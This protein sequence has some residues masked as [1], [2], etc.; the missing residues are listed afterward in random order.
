MKKLKS[1]VIVVVMALVLLVTGVF[2]LGGL[3]STKA[4]A[5]TQ[6][7]AGYYFCD[8]VPIMDE[9]TLRIEYKMNNIDYDIQPLISSQKLAYLVYTGYFWGLED[10]YSLVIVDIKAMKPDAQTLRDLFICLKYQN[11]NVIFVSAYEEYE[12]GDATLFM[13]YVDD[14]MPCDL[15]R[16]GNFVDYS[17]LDMACWNLGYS[18][19]DIK[20]G[21]VSI[22]YSNLD[23]T[24][25]GTCILIDG[26]FIGVF[27]PLLQ[28]YNAKNILAYST[29][30][31]RLILD[32]RYGFES[33]ERADF[34]FEM[35]RELW[36]FY[37]FN[38]IVPWDDRIEY[39]NIDMLM[40]FWQNSGY[41]YEDFLNH[42]E[43]YE[44]YY[45]DV[46]W[47]CFAEGIDGKFEGIFKLFKDN[48]RILVHFPDSDNFWDII[49]SDE[50]TEKKLYEFTDIE[51]W[52][53][54]VE[55]KRLYAMVICP[56][57]SKFYDILYGSQIKSKERIVRAVYIWSDESIEW[58]G[59]GLLVVDLDLLYEMHGYDYK[60]KDYTELQNKL[61]EMIKNLL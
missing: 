50:N 8:S 23:G 36:Q 29:F 45:L 19:T 39:G 61:L 58:D 24:W 59:R 55:N 47:D 42:Y 4:E 49:N 43:E 33:E 25:A 14:F 26:R 18:Y 60:Y 13:E 53:E 9:E 5:L 16:Y 21:T 17:V 40:D 3:K 10:K 48:I 37:Y 44:E 22:D 12:Y 34:E 51:G 31:Q 1:R 41:R 38:F 35:Y 54:G 6:S 7:Q 32:I 28:K 15:D 30:L 11:C 2:A 46:I 52:Y 56:L 57:N 20:N 27:D